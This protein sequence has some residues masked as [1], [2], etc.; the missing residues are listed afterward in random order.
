MVSTRW[1]TQEISNI[2]KRGSG[3]AHVRHFPAADSLDDTKE[4][5][6]THR[7]TSGE[8]AKVPMQSQK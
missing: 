8:R 2:N 6:K 7:R 1:T 4:I 3:K 5:S